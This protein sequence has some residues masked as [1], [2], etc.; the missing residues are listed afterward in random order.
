MFRN[1]SEFSNS[2][3]SSRRSFLRRLGTGLAIG[4]TAKLGLAQSVSAYAYQ[5][6]GLCYAPSFCGCASG[7]GWCWRC[8]NDYSN[9]YGY[10]CCE[11]FREGYTPRGDTC[12]GVWCS[13]AYQQLPNCLAP[14]P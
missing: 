14:A 11:C 12:T 2:S 1:R 6:C 4:V 13:W 9:G 10:T 3:D 5:C 8:C 7:R